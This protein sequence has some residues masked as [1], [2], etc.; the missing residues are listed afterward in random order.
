VFIFASIYL[1]ANV[2]KT[3]LSNAFLS[4]LSEKQRKLYENITE[5]R[6]NTYFKGFGFGFLL[7]IAFIAFQNILVSKSSLL[8][9]NNKYQM[10]SFIA[11]T[12][13]LSTYFYYMLAPKSDYMVMHLENQEQKREW[14]NIYKKM[15]FHYH[16]GL[17]LGILG[18]FF[19]G[20]VY[21]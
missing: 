19:F 1:S 17:A 21:C 8:R 14:L 18:M 16:A 3:N 2:D 11:A 6:K 9:L 5:E 4:T 10:G 12:T 7:S 15:Q 20:M 13:L